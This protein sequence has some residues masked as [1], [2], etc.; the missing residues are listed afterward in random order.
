MNPAE[1][2]SGDEGTNGTAEG[3]ESCRSSQ[4]PSPTEP[5][6]SMTHIL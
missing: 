2:A 6:E 3:Y 4:V 5:S 1:E